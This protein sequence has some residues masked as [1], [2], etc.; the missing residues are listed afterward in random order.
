MQK[1]IDP[2]QRIIR[3]EWPTLPAETWPETRAT[4]HM[5]TQ[6]VGKLRLALSPPQN[7]FWH[8]TLYLSAH[9]LTTSP[10]PYRGEV[11]QVDF[12]FLAHQLR[13]ETSWGSTQALALEPKSVA[14]FYAE[15]MATLRAL[16]VD[17]HIWPH[18]VEIPEPIPFE[19][20]RVHAAY[21][22]TAAQAFWRMLVQAD[23]VLK[24]FRG[25]FLG[26]SSP[27][28]FFWGSFDLAVTRFSGRRAPMWHGPALNVSPH[29]MHASYS[30]EVSSAGFWP[31]DA[32]APSI[33]YCYAVPEPAGFAQARVDPAEATYSAEMGEFVLPYE[34][35]RSA[36]HPD[37]ALQAFL[38][39]TYAAAADLGGWD[40]PLLEERPTCLCEVEGR[41]QPAFP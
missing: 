28:H 4:L 21:D 13:I 25:R 24:R 23:R 20:D 9:G 35:V 8:S 29:V 26:K 2:D 14:D 36:A 16:G 27:V 1:R 39:T 19:Q 6:I 41:P 31:G 32:T 10:L 30:H 3:A 12:D 15:V 17:V 18:P 34:A 33:F 37:Q 5:W 40:R 22:P 38:E 11:L 7:H